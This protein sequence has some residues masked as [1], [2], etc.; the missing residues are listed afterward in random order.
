MGITRRTFLQHSLATSAAV[1]A[2]AMGANEQ[3][4]VAIVGIH[5]RGMDLAEACSK[6]KN[7]VIRYLADPDSRLFEDR[8]RI[9]EKATGARPKCV[10]DFRTLLD[11]PDLDA[12][13]IATPDHWHAL[14]TVLACQAGKDVYVE[15]PTSHSIWESRQ[16]IAAARK[17]RRIVQVGTQNRSAAYCND[18]VEYVRQGNLGDVHF[19]RVMNSKARAP[20]EA[21]ADAPAPPEVDYDLWLGPAPQR[22]FNENR[23]HYQWHWFWDYSGGDLINDGVHQMDLAR[24]ISGETLPKAV[25]GVAANHVLKDSRE[26]P[27]TQSITWEF[28][29]LTLSLEQTLWSPYMK[30]HAFD[31]RDKEDLPNWPFAGT[32]IEVYGTKNFMYLGR[33]GGGWQVIDGDGKTIALKSGKFSP[34]N[35]AH[36]ANFLDSV[37]SRKTP[38]ADIEEGHYSTLLGHY[39]NIACRVG[40]RLHIDPKTEGFVDSAQAEDFVKRDYRQG[41]VV[42]KIE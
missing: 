20:M 41:F 4:N 22:P 12:L 23:F 40:Q 33:M 16:M 6:C 17:Y 11:D 39:G 27:D 1:S 25:S 14:A 42:P 38:H 34:A 8:A 31:L 9:I 30:K 13:F 18:A 35:T 29:S 10:Q 36:V 24:W 21:K 3:I 28:D 32:R 15:K 19:I 26:T 2:G 37:R 7:V 5:D